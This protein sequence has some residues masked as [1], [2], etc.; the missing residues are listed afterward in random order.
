MVNII[1][2]SKRQLWQDKLHEMQQ[3]EQELKDKYGAVYKEDVLNEMIDEYKHNKQAEILQE[4]KE[5]DDKIKRIS[6]NNLESLES[7]K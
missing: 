4:L 7:L 6:Q 2:Q 5:Y 1:E 3:G